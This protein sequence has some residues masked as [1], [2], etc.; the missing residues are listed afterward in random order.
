M[1]VWVDIDGAAHSGC[2]Q[3][4]CECGTKWLGQGERHALGWYCPVAPLA[5]VVLHLNLDHGGV[6]L[7]LRMSPRYRDWLGRYWS[8][9]QQ[10]RGVVPA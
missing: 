7:E 4:T 8:R 5:E 2:Y 6:E 10:M 1:T 9:H 3:C